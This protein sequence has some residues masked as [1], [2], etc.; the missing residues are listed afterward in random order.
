M[1]NDNSAIHVSKGVATAYVGPDATNLFRCK[2]LKLSIKMHRQ[3]GMIPTRGVTITKMFRLAEQYTGQMYK[4]GEHLRAEEDLQ[5]WIST[6]MSA[7]PII[8][9]E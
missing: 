3:T 4:R 7:L 1:T 6:M 5:V 8:N 9:E 2:M